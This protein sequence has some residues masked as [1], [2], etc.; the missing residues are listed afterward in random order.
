MIYNEVCGE[1]ISSLGY[2]AMR[3]PTL[4]DK[5]VDMEIASKLFKIA[6]ENGI[7]YFDTAWGYSDGKNET[8]VGEILSAYDR[9]SFYLASKFPGY[10]T[11]NAGLVEEI[12]EKQ[13]EKC[14]VD[15][16]DFYLFHNVCEGNID[17]YLDKKYGIFDYL[18]RQKEL[19]RIKHLGFSVH[20]KQDTFERFLEAYG[21]DMEFCQIQLNYLDWEFQ[22]AKSKVRLLNEMNIPIFVMEPVR[23]GKL[24]SVGEEY[25]A[26]FKNIRSDENEVGMAFRFVQSIDGVKMTLSGMNTEEQLLANLK[27]FSKYKPFNNEEMEAVLEVGK[28]M[29]LSKSLPCTGCKYCVEYCPKG[30]DIPSLISLYN[31]HT[32]TGGGFIAPM[33]IG[34]MKESERPSACIGCR[35]CEAVCPQN[36]KISEAFS[37]FTNK[38]K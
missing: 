4:P 14:R 16:F 9:S 22:D 30:L 11:A 26:V 38:L 27:T 21:K 1:K 36:I 34:A 18:M 37:D 15:Y 6:I 28:K 8:A 19:G 32:L 10:D 20:A 31:E 25:K 12:F 13:L 33:R 23:G 29:A 5:T 7:N 24:A 3:L 2:G 35:S 17:I